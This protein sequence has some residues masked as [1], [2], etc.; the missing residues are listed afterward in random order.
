MQC[1]CQ[2]ISLILFPL[3]T[4][5]CS[6]LYSQ[7]ISQDLEKADSLKGVLEENVG[8]ARV[9]ILYDITYEYIGVDDSKAL[10]YAEIAWRELQD[11]RDS[12]MYV[13]IGRLMASALR[14]LERIDEA[15]AVYRSI[16]PVARRHHWQDEVNVLLNSFAYTLTLRSDY[17]TALMLYLEAIN[18]REKLDDKTGLSAAYNNVGLLYYKIKYYEKALYYFLLSLNVKEA[19]GVRADLDLVNINIGLCYCYLGQYKSGMEY[20]RKGTAICKGHCADNI[21]VGELFAKGVANL[22]MGRRKAAVDCFWDSYQRSVQAGNLRFQAENMVYLARLANQDKDYK[23]ALYYLDISQRCALYGGYRL[24][25]SDGY[26][27]MAKANRGLLDFCKE[28]FNWNLYLQYRDS[29]FS[30]D[31][32]NSLLVAQV[33][34]EQQQNKIVLQLKALVTK[35]QSVQNLYICLIGLLL[36]LTISV[37]LWDMRNRRFENN[38]LEKQVGESTRHLEERV[39]LLERRE[40]ERR[41]W[42]DKLRGALHA[43]IVRLEGLGGILENEGPRKRIAQGVEAVRSVL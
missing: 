30:E 9:S 8:V 2:T 37:L 17:K 22:G 14:R 18:I 40:N 28:E 31:L 35:R 12:V 36:L 38:L 6:Q 29:I 20:I 23:Q 4:I 21:I 25:L 27:E 11:L 39:R 42:D 26:L 13:R 32:A 43:G 16:L 34:H 33:D 24:L 7:D 5:G 41:I 19:A 10:E 1:F 15:I 3:I